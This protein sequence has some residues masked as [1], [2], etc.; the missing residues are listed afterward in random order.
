MKGTEAKF[1]PPTPSEI[2]LPEKLGS[3][4]LVSFIKDVFVDFKD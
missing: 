1:L 2:G 4:P 3:F